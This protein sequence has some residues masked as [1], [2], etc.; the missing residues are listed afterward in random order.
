M[1][2]PY[3]QTA[4]HYI[5]SQ[6]YNQLNIINM[7]TMKLFS[8]ILIFGCFY[9][10]STTRQY[11][12]IYSVRPVTN[13]KA[14]WNKTYYEDEN[15]IVSYNFW[16]SH[17]SMGFVFHNK[18]DK[19][20]YLNKEES[21]FISNGFAYNYYQNRSYSYSTSVG[22][23]IAS[24][25]GVS[26][27]VGVGMV[28]SE[29]GIN[30]NNNLQTNANSLA[31]ARGISK[32]AVTGIS[33]SQSKMV[34]YGEEKIIIIPPKTSKNVM[35]YKIASE[36][37]RGCELHLYPKSRKSNSLPF[38]EENSPLVFGNRIS[39]TLEDSP[40]RINIEN[41][42]YVSGITNYIEKDIVD[43]KEVEDCHERDNN[44]HIK[45]IITVFNDKFVSPTGFY[46]PYQ[47]TKIR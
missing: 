37:Y 39:Y 34:T 25:T 32:S 16:S 15:C 45:E 5:Q 17:G 19:Y 35:G 18:T 7:N 26:L 44:N 47:R 4:T 28:G 46:V 29:S 23:N 36:L 9:S 2:N 20:I 33:T 1:D 40:E 27:S 41:M 24:G 43:K 10:C 8:A 30:Y 6:E 13:M 38:I 14:D 21:F 22:E 42:F 31:I 3:C 12:Q 11:Y